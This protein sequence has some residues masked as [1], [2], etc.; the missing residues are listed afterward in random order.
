MGVLQLDRCL[1]SKSDLTNY[2]H[3][4]QEVE[5]SPKGIT[6]GNMIIPVPNGQIEVEYEIHDES[7]FIARPPLETFAT[8]ANLDEAKRKFQQALR[9][10]YKF[11]KRHKDELSQRLNAHLKIYEQL[12]G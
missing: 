1:D 7:V 11:L 8:G 9:S 4:E 3:L 2:L 6:F 5:K 10:D 12:L